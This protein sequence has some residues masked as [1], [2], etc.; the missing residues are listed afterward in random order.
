MLVQV[1]YQHF[2]AT[3][4]IHAFCSWRLSIK[5]GRVLIIA[6]SIAL[7]INLCIPRL[8]GWEMNQSLLFMRFWI[9]FNSLSPN[10]VRRN[11]ILSHTLCYP[12]SSRGISPW[13]CAKLLYARK[14]LKKSTWCC[15]TTFQVPSLLPLKLISYCQKGFGFYFM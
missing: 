6:L 1:L 13:Q 11:E 5:I 14:I 12:F 9:S 7:T 8:K 3:S 10:V 4:I 2:T 15:I